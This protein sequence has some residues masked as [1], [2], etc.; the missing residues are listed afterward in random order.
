MYNLDD[1]AHN[2]FLV[3]FV[4]NNV[5]LFASLHHILCNCYFFIKMKN[6][7]DQTLNTKSM[8]NLLCA[9]I[10]FINKSWDFEGFKNNLGSKYKYIHTLLEIELIGPLV[11]L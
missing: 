7:Y 2:N 10:L 1:N 11:Y 4:I 3:D 6:T 8:T 5:M 9:F